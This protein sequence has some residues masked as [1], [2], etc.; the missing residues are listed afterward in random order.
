MNYEQQLLH[1]RG[2]EGDVPEW[3]AEW[4]ALKIGN[5]KYDPTYDYLAEFRNRYI[6]EMDNQYG[7]GEGLLIFNG[8]FFSD[9]TSTDKHRLAYVYWLDYKYA[10]F[11]REWSPKEKDG[12]NYLYITF[13]FAKYMPVCI[14]QLE[15]ERIINLSI[16]KDCKLTYCYE[17]YTEDGFHPHVHMLVELKRTGHIKPCDLKQKIFQKKGLDTVLNINYKLSWAS[18]YK[19]RTSKRAVHIAYCNGM[20]IEKKQENCEK[21]E[22]WR[23]EHN[24][25]KI[26]IKDN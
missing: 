17:Y 2:V 14:V 20:K 11:R 15:M 1:N 19:D 10:D 12:L 26:Y 18:S 9:E 6:K 8:L 7:K 3:K 4:E 24:L 13:N 22:K 21:D 16:F 5:Y 25:E 23:Q